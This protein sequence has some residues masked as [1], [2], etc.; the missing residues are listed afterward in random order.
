MET[1]K[2]FSYQLQGH[3]KSEDFAKGILFLVNQ[4]SNV[5]NTVIEFR[6]FDGSDMVELYAHKQGDYDAEFDRVLKHHFKQI[7]SKEEATLLMVGEYE[8]YTKTVHRKIDELQNND[9]EYII[10]AYQN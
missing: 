7:V 3:E 9:G 10:V 2:I 8:D 6:T 5:E 4:R 1:T